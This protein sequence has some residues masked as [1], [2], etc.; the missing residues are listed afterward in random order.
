MELATSTFEVEQA[1]VAKHAK[2]RAA[3][4]E[5]VVA[6]TPKAPAGWKFNELGAKGCNEIVPESHSIRVC[7]VCLGLD[8]PN[9]IDIGD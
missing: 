5:P 1:F 2:L 4:L 8:A 9:E 3:A 6:E 7:R